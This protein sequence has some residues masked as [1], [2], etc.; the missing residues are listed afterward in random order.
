VTLAPEQVDAFFTRLRAGQIP[1][2]ISFWTPD[3][4]D[5]LNYTAFLPGG[6]YDG[7]TNWSGESSSAIYQQLKSQSEQ[8]QITTDNAQRVELFKQIQLALRDNGP[9]V[10]LIQPSL[11]VA[12]SAQLKGFVFNPQWRLDPYIV[13]RQ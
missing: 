3:F 2:F 5:A 7:R 11:P 9:F 1:F 4:L 13:S 6:I 10:S 8:V 12:V